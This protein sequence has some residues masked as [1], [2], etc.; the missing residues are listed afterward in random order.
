MPQA[1]YTQNIGTP[2]LEYMLSSDAVRLALAK[3]LHR[4]APL[5]QGLTEQDV[6][7]RNRIFWAIYCLE[8]QIACQA[9]RPS[10]CRRAW[11]K[12]G[13]DSVPDH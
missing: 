3:G 10:V 4:A 9:S 8:K 6:E 11:G 1:Y 12:V 5:S 2:C 7:Q 13:A